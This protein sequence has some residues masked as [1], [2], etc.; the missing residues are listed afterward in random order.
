M[1]VSP[2][3]ITQQFTRARAAY[4]CLVIKSDTEWKHSAVVCY[5]YHHWSVYS[6]GLRQ[7]AQSSYSRSERGS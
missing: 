4:I 1:Q 7:L 6:A 2:Y 5:S 3:P